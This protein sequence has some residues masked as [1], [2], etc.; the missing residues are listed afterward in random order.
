MG[1]W[2]LNS[3]SLYH[4]IDNLCDTLEMAICRKAMKE[5]RVGDGG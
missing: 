5:D 3:H 4:K 2:I 1:S